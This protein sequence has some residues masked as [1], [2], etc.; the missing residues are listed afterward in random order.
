MNSIEMANRNK[1]RNFGLILGVVLSAPG[2]VF[3]YKKHG[4]VSPLMVLAC[5][6]VVLAVVCPGFLK[7]VH[8]VMLTIGGVLGKINSCIVLVVVYYLILTPMGIIRKVFILIS[9]RRLL[10]SPVSTYWLKKEVVN[11]KTNMEKQF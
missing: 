6:L 8:K 4:V 11:L 1:L 7:P 3:S 10:K 5:L 9:N 2:L